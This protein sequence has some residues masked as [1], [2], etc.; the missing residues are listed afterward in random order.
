LAKHEDTQ[1]PQD[2]KPPE[3]P[4]AEFFEDE[5]VSYSFLFFLVSGALLFVTL[6]SF[7][8]DEYSR[9]GF[10]KYQ[11]IYNKTQYLRAEEDWKKI[12]AEIR[13]KEQELKKALQQESGKL[14]D[15]RQFQALAE[16]VRLAKIRMDDQ[17]DQ[18][19]F[20]ISRLD[21]HYYYYKKAMHENRNFDAEL[22]RV[23]RSQ[24]KIKELEQIVLQREQEYKDI[25]AKLLALKANQIKYDAELRKLTLKREDLERAM[26]YY[27]PFPFVW[28][29]AEILQTVILGSAKNSFAEVTYKVDRCMTC[30]ISYGDEYYKDQENPLKAHPNPDILIKKHPPEKT[31]CT[32]CHKGQGPATAP[33]EDAHG[34]HHEGDQTV[35]IN[36]PILQGGMMQSNCQNCHAEV[37]TLP[38]APLLTKGKQLFIRLGCHGC[39]LV[40]GYQSEAKV[41]PR[42]NR[43]AAKVNP[44]WLYQW[45]M[46][47]KE[48]LSKTRMPNFGFTAKDGMSVTA[49]LL[50]K[51]EKDYQLSNKYQAGNPE[52]G[53]KLFESV[54]C[55]AC[56]ELNGKGEVFGPDLSNIAAKT[57]PDWLVTW[58]SD[59][60]SYNHMSVMPNLRLKPQEASDIASYLMTFG[61]PKIIKDIEEFTSDP[62][63][64]EYGEKVIRQRGCF[65]CHEIPGMEKEGRIAPE[66]SAFGSKQVN[67][68][69]FGDT[70]TARSWEAWVRTKLKNPSSF[71]T[72]RVLDKMPNFG[73]APDEIDALV[74]LLKGLNG[75]RL[76][77]EYR[78]TLN[79]TEQVVEKGRRIIDKYNC[80]GCHHVEGEG[81][82]I[83]KYLDATAQYP[84]PLEKGDYHVGER[85]QGSWLFSFLKEPTPVRK[86]LKVRM[87]TFMF[88]DQQV[89]DITAYFEAMAPQ[90][91]QYDAGVHK[92][93]DKEKVDTGIKMVNYMECGNCHDEGAKGIEFKIAAERLRHRW[94]SK[95]LKDTQRLIPWTKMPNHWPR[96]EQGE[97][98]IQNKFAKLKQVEGGDVEKQVSDIRDFIVSYNQ[99]G[100]DTSISMGSSDGGGDVADDEADGKKPATGGK[101][102]AK[103]KKGGDDDDDEDD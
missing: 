78:R 79:D 72:E 66:L 71:R 53:L 67:E 59:P 83:Q 88:T 4:K 99:P 14:E 64:I 74:V 22:S 94:I 31:G 73:L 40:D 58:L 97:Y 13:A 8:D 46:N 35:G 28:R 38:G 3:P 77:A 34:S 29:P 42:L 101:K 48:Y 76:P 1:Q 6:W 36:E 47:P 16:E 19:K 27:K 18:R 87:P 80:R 39:H 102:A 41:G 96:N 50:A 12:D 51:S 82:V 17:K 20:E 37:V 26:G 7:Y 25:E 63:N 9:R 85:I 62:K 103:A 24:E 92:A 44:T 43:I 30:H 11:D 75:N 70:H 65:A 100:L 60:K 23:H 52:N 21:E 81:G 98:L 5:K 55:L 10:K 93:K 2:E 89:R 69:E 49:Y 15:S 86:W 33:A 84:P 56:H 68:L 61:T 32:W 90:E 45:V 95:W 54:G 57:N 91:N